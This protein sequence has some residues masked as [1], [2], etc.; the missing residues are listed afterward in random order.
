MNTTKKGFEGEGLKT[1]GKSLVVLAIL[2]CLLFSGILFLTNLGKRDLWRPDEPRYAEVARE[3]VLN[4]QYL[5]PSINHQPYTQKP[6]LFFWLVAGSFKAFQKINEWTARFPVA[7]SAVFCI[8]M[9][10]LIGKRLFDTSA[11]FFSALLLATTSEFFWLANRVN[12]DTTMTLFILVSLYF[13]VRGLEGGHRRNLW[14][15]LAFLSAG[16]ATLVKGPLGLIVPFLTLIVYL[17]LKG[18]FRTLKKVPWFSGF[19]IFLLILAAGLV[20]TCL[21]GGKAYTQELIFRQTVTRY[22][23]G[24]NHQKGFFYYFYT[25]PEALLPWVIFLPAAIFF[26]LGKG[27]EKGTRSSLLFV[28]VWALANLFFISFSKSKRVLYVLSLIPAVCLFL[29]VYLSAVYRGKTPPTPW[30]KI[31]VYILG[32]LGIVAGVAF[33]FAPYAVKF[34]FPDLVLPS[35]PF[36]LMG[37]LMIVSGAFLCFLNGAKK[38]K[39]VVWVLFLS[40]FALFFVTARWVMPQFNQVKSLRIVGEEIQAMKDKGYDVRMLC[41]L[42]PMGILFYTKLAYLPV[43]PPAQWEMDFLKTTPKAAVVL[44]KRQLADFARMAGVPLK[45]LWK[46]KAGGRNFLILQ[47]EIP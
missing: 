16:V 37:I 24:I 5:V 13:I 17:F 33:P 21:A 46:G 47:P 10:F 39:A 9:T 28:V 44:T 1:D 27:R 4:H 26:V 2:G 32:I 19:G 42:E 14:F 15:R 25:F 41:G 22:L 18:D 35:L 43:V 45:V 11:G 40:Y 6:P 30:F 8:L 29:G 38:T 7:L 34:R 31:P 3:M 12:L 20:P 36:V 23:H